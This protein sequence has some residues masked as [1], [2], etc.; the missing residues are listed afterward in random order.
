MQKDKFSP[1]FIFYYLNLLKIHYCIGGISLIDFTKYG[2]INKTSKNKIDIYLLEKSILKLSLF[3]I[4]I[5]FS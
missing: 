5:F 2:V 3:I 4:L 1:E